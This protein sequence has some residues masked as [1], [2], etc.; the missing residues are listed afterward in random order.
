MRASSA[1][2]EVDRTAEWM[3]RVRHT[4]TN[5]R[6][7]QWQGEPGTQPALALQLAAPALRRAY[8]AAGDRSRTVCRTA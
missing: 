4:H 1:T 7:E 6:A 3:A 5:L 2:A 8:S